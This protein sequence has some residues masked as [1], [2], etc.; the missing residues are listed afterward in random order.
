MAALAPGEDANG[1]RSNT[2]SLQRYA[3][4]LR[5]I[6]RQ[7][8]NKHA[9]H[10]QSRRVL[11]D[12]AADTQCLREA[13]ASEL[14]R[15]GGLN[16]RHYPSVGFPIEH[17][18]SFGL[19]V[20]CFLPLLS[21]ETDVTTNAIHHHGHMLLTTVTTFGPGYDH[22]R[23]TTPKLVD[24]AREIFSI[25]FVDREVHRLG[26]V[27]FVD[28]FI[29]HAV[30]YPPSLTVTLALWSSCHDVSWRDHLKMVPAIQ[31]RSDWL[32]QMARRF[33]L[34]RALRVNARSYFDYYPV[35]DGFRG[36]RDRI[37][38]QRG[39]NEDY[40]H[41][42]FHILQQTG[43]ED[44][45]PSVQDRA[46]LPIDNPR[47]VDQLVHDLRRGAPIAHRFSE[48]LHHLD[49]MNFKIQAIERALDATARRPHPVD[50]VAAT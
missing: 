49:H 26:H 27:A 35:Q 46:R 50:A 5:R 7:A 8:S 15:P 23:F 33:G 14:Q 16:T 4:E 45:A 3:A 18:A 38:F 30:L 44:L 21:G 40:L 29:P 9:A 11:L 20:N 42:L 36:M 24:G 13:I 39:P 31:A 37:Q 28:Q 1:M 19:V 2:P 22:W 17:N 47:L 48:G 43:N 10:E 25:A 34:V 32:L 6:F 41:T 12:M